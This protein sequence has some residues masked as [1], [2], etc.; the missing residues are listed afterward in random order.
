MD[1]V[2]PSYMGTETLRLQL[3]KAEPSLP[4]TLTFM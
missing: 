1:L 2:L 3:H 4:Q